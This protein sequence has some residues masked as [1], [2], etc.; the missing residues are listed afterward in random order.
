[1]L[2]TSG[3]S[4][5]QKTLVHNLTSGNI[6]FHSS[7][8]SIVHLP[9]DLPM[10]PPSARGRI[11]QVVKELD[12]KPSYLLKQL[13]VVIALLPSHSIPANAMDR[14]EAQADES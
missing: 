6:R 13:Q 10:L 5:A 8:V 11:V 12:H 9:L 7:H 14:G 2:P 4:I 3:M 1:M